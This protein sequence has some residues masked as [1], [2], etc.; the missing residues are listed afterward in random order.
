M[1]GEILAPG[2]VDLLP[3]IRARREETEHACQLPAD[4]A[5]SLRETGIFSLSVPRALGGREA[6]P[7]DLMDTIETV[8][9]ADG[10]TGW[11]AMVGTGN[12]VASGYTSEAGAREVWADPK[13]PTAGI[14]A[15]AGQAVRG[16]GGVRVNRRWPFASGIT[17]CDWVWAGCLVMEDGQPRMTDQG[18]EI[19]HVAMRVDEVTIHDTWRVSGLCG[20]GSHDFSASDVFVPGR[21]VF[22]CSIRPDT[23]SSPSTRCRRW[24]SSS[25][26]LPA[27]A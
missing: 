7:T 20:T 26:S 16:D 23:A 18:P 14:A 5:G 10:S 8:A 9:A 21:R 11:C 25:T 4:L 2:L 24:A 12:N 17:H 15:P 27:W 13:R 3:T 22:R 6:S 19:I 1:P